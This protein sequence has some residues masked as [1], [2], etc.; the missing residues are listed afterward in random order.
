MKCIIRW[1]IKL[2]FEREKQQ[3]TVKDFKEN[4]GYT[5]IDQ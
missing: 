1:I 3:Q 5:R 4:N 2:I